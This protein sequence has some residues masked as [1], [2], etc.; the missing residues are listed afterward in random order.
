MT[1]GERDEIR[2]RLNR[3]VE[4]HEP[5]QVSWTM[6]LFSL[7]RGM[8]SR[9]KI[10]ATTVLVVFVLALGGSSLAMAADI[11]LPGDAFYP[12]KVSVV[13]PIRGA[14]KGRA[15]GLAS[16]HAS[17]VTTRLTE[18]ETLAGE[19]EL[20]DARREEIEKLLDTHTVAF[21]RALGEVEKEDSPATAEGLTTTFKSSIITHVRLLNDITAYAST[22]ASSTSA[23]SARDLK[24]KAALHVNDVGASWTK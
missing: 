21:T 7:W 18:A 20:N 8:E 4:T 15:A 23:R 22:S 24:E 3:F 17:L 10:I 16:W 19:G 14:F 6:N 5:V 12:V 1:S 9:H 13:E 11:A 2:A